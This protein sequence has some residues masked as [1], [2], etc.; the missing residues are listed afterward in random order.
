MNLWGW[1]GE[2]EEERMYVNVATMENNIA[3]SLQ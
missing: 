1:G 3:S 2:E